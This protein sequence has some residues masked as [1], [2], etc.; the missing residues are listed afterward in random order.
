MDVS[1]LPCS[2]TR[3]PF[4]SSQLQGLVDWKA[5]ESHP[6]PRCM[7]PQNLASAGGCLCS[8]GNPFLLDLKRNVSGPTEQTQNLVGHQRHGSGLLG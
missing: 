2:F 6:Q 4:A 8:Q 7:W 3:P 1:L 5:A